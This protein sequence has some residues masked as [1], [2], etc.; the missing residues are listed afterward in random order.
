M[1]NRVQ[2][3]RAFAVALFVAVVTL[4]IGAWSPVA[5]ASTLPTL[6]FASTPAASTVS[7]TV[8]IAGAAHGHGAGISDVSIT[9]DLLGLTFSADV[10]AGG[11]FSLSLPLELGDNHIEVVPIDGTGASGIPTAF[12]VER[13]LPATPLLT[14]DEPNVNYQQTLESSIDIRGRV[15]TTLPI[16]DIAVRLG[17]HLAVPTQGDDAYEYVFY[18]VALGDGLNQIEVTVYSQYGSVNEAVSVDAVSS[19]NPDDVGP[20]PTI[21]LAVASDKVVVHDSTFV[22]AGVVRAECL[23]ELL[24]DGLAPD[25]M[26]DTGMGE[27]SFSTELVLDENTSYEVAITAVACDGAES[28]VSVIFERDDT[29]PVV[30]FTSP[31]PSPDIH[32]VNSNPV[33]VTGY[34]D[35]PN[36]VGAMFSGFPL[37]LEPSLEEGRW[38]FDVTVKLDRGQETG[39]EVVAWNSAGQSG[40]SVVGV[41]LEQSVDLEL[42]SPRSGDSF[43]LADGE[44]EVGAEARLR[45]AG[46]S[47]SVWFQLDEDDAVLGGSGEGDHGALLGPLAGGESHTVTVW[48]EDIHGAVLA[49]STAS[50]STIDLASI[51]ISIFSQ[52]PVEGAENIETNQPLTL[53]FNRQVDPETIEVRVFET[54]HGFVYEAPSDDTDLRN[55]SNVVRVEVEHEHEPIAGKAQNLPGDRIYSFSPTNPW[56]YGADIDV[57]V[58]VD[59]VHTASTNFGVRDFPNL[60]HGFALDDYFQPLSGVEVSL[61]DLGHETVSDANGEF[62]F[63]WGWPADRTL[64]P[65]RHRVVFNPEGKNPRLAMVEGWIDVVAEENRGG[66]SFVVPEIPMSAR[67]VS[68]SGEEAHV[69][70][71][72]LVSLDLEDAVLTF[73]D[74]SSSGLVAPHLTDVASAGYPTSLMELPLFAL[75]M[76]PG[77]VTVSG[78]LSMEVRL[79]KREGSYDYLASLVNAEGRNPVGILYALDPDTLLLSPAGVVEF[80]PQT[81]RAVMP[82]KTNLVERL[83]V[84]AFGIAPIHAIPTALQYLDGDVEFDAVVASLVVTP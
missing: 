14:I 55:M 72:G 11:N 34:V 41:R 7:D 26:L 32:V 82:R 61:P 64:E 53:H 21:E 59:G 28:G 77:G 42:L 31:L 70:E 33:H 43:T 29:P 48:A 54:V 49:Q 38:T 23:G 65:G 19:L 10:D 60:V 16:E 1:V 4:W 24:V 69:L 17:E 35:E 74:G 44:V 79:P 40:S 47:D 84:L 63:G 15:F 80:D 51:P 8:L 73:P 76:D 66:L 22:L 12:D 56:T 18:D 83:D 20:P 30:V 75:R 57:E 36:L 13:T 2:S 78:D 58:W 39:L 3:V 71:N 46:S 5:R 9:S 37:E 52:T 6:E 67:F 62:G 50:F 25:Q 27:H 45:D 68:L 81:M